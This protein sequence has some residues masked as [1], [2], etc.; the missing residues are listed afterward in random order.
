MEQKNKQELVDNINIDIILKFYPMALSAVSIICYFI[1]FYNVGYFPAISGSDIFYFGGLIFFVSFFISLLF[2]MPT[3]F[4]PGYHNDKFCMPFI[5]SVFILLV[6]VFML[7]LLFIGKDYVISLVV[8]FIACVSYIDCI[9][10]FDKRNKKEMIVFVLLLIV[11]LLLSCVVYYN[12]TTIEFTKLVLFA[13]LIMGCILALP[14]S[15][16][17][18]KDIYNNKGYKWLF[19]SMIICVPIY[20]FLLF[21][22]SIAGWLEIGNINYKYI[23]VEKSALGTFPDEISKNSTNIGS[24]KTYYDENKISGTIKLYNIKALS[25]LGKFYYLETIGYGKDQEIRFELDASK[26]IS[27][28][29]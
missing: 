13:F 7:S 29:K 6:L 14:I 9:V 21:A 8:S 2:I 10:F 17:I 20:S 3:I 18:A 27:R 16:Y 23:V 25:T 19:V 22:N 12:T 5:V 15:L 11:T 4:F 1:Y 26:I 28:K 24:H